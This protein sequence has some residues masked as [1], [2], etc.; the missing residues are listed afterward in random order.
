[1]KRTMVDILIAIFHD[2][3]RPETAAT[4]S[5]LGTT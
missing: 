3:R 4:A 1:M 2:Q 5:G